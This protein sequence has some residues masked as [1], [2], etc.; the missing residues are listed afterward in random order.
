MFK[1]WVMDREAYDERRAIMEVE[2][3]KSLDASREAADAAFATRMGIACTAAANGDWTA[4][5]VWCRELAN[6]FGYEMA[7][8]TWDDL[9]ENLRN[10]LQWRQ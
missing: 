3:V 9:K 7:R 8:A 5:R 6:R 4:A 1:Q 2:G 10:E